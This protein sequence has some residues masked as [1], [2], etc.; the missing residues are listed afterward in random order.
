MS[1]KPIAIITAIAPISEIGIVTSGTSALR[2][3]PRNRKTMRPTIATVSVKVVRD[4][5]ER[6]L[7]VDRAVI[8]ERDLHALRQVGC[9]KLELRAQR[10]GDADFVGARQRP[11]REIDR[12]LAVVADVGGFF[13]RAQ[14]DAAEI[15]NADDP[16]AVLAHDEAFELLDASEVGVGEEVDLDLVALRPPDRREEVVARERGLDVRGVQ[17]KADRRSASSQ[18]RMACGRAPSRPTR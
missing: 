16:V 7:H 5:L 2:A 6:V 9:D 4:L 11:D 12:V 3:E 10:L 1:E 8:G 17:P 14:F 15:G 13:F 18:M